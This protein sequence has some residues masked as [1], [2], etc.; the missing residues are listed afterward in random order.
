MTQTNSRVPATIAQ[1][2][3]VLRIGGGLGIAGCCVGLLVL[4][5]ACFGFNFALLLGFIPVVMGAV[6]FVLAV[7]GGFADKHAEG[8]HVAAA[9][10]INVAALAG[11]AMI[12]WAWQH[13]PKSV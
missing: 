11:G 5:S 12:L 7:V 9:L 8:S 13:W 1:Q 4:L 6:G 10:F 2:S 3:T